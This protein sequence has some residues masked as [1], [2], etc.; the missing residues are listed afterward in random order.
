VSRFNAVR[1]SFP[2]VLF[3]SALG[4]QEADSHRLND[5]EK[6]TVDQVPNVQF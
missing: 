6:G 3:A 1:E 2:A 5:S 4:F